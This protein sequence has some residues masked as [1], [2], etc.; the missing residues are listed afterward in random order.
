[1]NQSYSSDLFIVGNSNGDRKVR[2]YLREWCDLSSAI[3]KEVRNKH[4]RPLQAPI[5][6]S[7]ILKCW[8]EVG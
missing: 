6:I 8:M 2:P 5:G 1:M 7:P 3:E 4:L